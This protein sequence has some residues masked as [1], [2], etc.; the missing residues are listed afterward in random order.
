[1]EKRRRVRRSFFVFGVM[2]SEHV[3]SEL[4]DR[5]LKSPGRSKEDAIVLAGITNRR[6]SAVRAGVRTA[7]RTEESVEPVERRNSRSERVSGQPFAQDAHPERVSRVLERLTGCQVRSVFGTE[8]A[9]DPDTDA[10]SDVIHFLKQTP[11]SLVRHTIIHAAPASNPNSQIPKPSLQRNPN[12]QTPAADGWS[13]PGA[14]E[15]WKL[16]FGVFIRISAPPSDRRTQH[17]ARAAS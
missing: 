7:R 3:A 14:F 4:D 11:R 10:G 12:V 2:D 1:D 6:Q 8:I 5:V 15:I 13:R 16:V 17:G 9:N